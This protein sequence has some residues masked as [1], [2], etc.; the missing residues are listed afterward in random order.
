MEDCIY[1]NAQIFG[2]NHGNH[3]YLFAPFEK[4]VES[5]IL[6]QSHYLKAIAVMEGLNLGFEEICLYLFRKDISVL[7]N[8][9][10]LHYSFFHLDIPVSRL[11]NVFFLGFDG[12]LFA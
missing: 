3:I 8:L 1:W 11:F 10:G 4:Y 12:A 7:F 5:E 2:G 6:H 9:L